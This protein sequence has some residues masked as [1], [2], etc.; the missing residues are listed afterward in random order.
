M[1][2]VAKY[3][4]GLRE[5]FAIGGCAPSHLWETTSHSSYHP[6]RGFPGFHSWKNIMIS[7]FLHRIYE[8]L[9]PTHENKDFLIYPGFPRFQHQGQ[10]QTISQFLRELRVDFGNLLYWFF[11]LVYCFYS[12][13]WN[14]WYRS[15]WLIN[16][17][18]MLPVWLWAPSWSL[19]LVIPQMVEPGNST[20]PSTQTSVQVHTG[21]LSSMNGKK[22]WRLSSLLRFVF[23]HT[24]PFQKQHK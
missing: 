20:L 5:I 17:F 23:R 2:F 6:A 13:I 3:K 4:A 19:A 14:Y 10:T 9:W 18:E 1:K 11:S 21:P 7:H 12:S 24:S 22:R 8:A 15:L 16:Q